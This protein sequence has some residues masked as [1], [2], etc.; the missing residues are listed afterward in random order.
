MLQCQRENVST[1]SDTRIERRIERAISLYASHSPTRKTIV[2][3]KGAANDNATI[4]LDD[5]CIDIAVRS[6]AGI[7]TQVNAAVCLKPGEIGPL[8]QIDLAKLSA[9]D[10]A[11]I[12]LQRQ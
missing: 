10:D 5:D 7:K 11:A 8:R 6:V 1:G 12:G 4:R 3:N 2:A 9:D